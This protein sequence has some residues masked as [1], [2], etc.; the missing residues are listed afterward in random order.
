MVRLSGPRALEIAARLFS[1]R[2]PVS[3][4]PP[5]HAELGTL[6]HP[7]DGRAIDQVLLLVMPGPQSFTG[8]DVVEFS[9]HGSPFLTQLLVEAA[10]VAGARPASPGEFTRR[11]VLNGRLD[12]TQAE[13]IADLIGARGERAL[14]NALAQLDGGLSRRL[15]ELREALLSALAPLEAFLDFGDDVPEAPG[16][17]A[18]RRQLAAV[19][20][21]LEALIG[22]RGCARLLTEG[23]R[24]VLCG[25]PNVGKSSLLNALTGL[26]RALVH[27]APG[28]TRD[29]VDVELQLAGLPVRLVDTAG[30]RVADDPVEQAGVVRARQSADA[31]T[32]LLFL[33][34]G[35]GPVTPEDRAAF[36][37]LSGAPALVVAGKS[38]LGVGPWAAEFAE[39]MGVRCCHLSARTGRGVPELLALL[40]ARLGQQA[41]AEEDMVM[42]RARHYEALERARAAVVRAEAGLD[43]GAWADMLAAELRLSLDALDDITGEAAGPELLDRIFHTFCIG[44]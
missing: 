30:L 27:D 12:L 38:D 39:N 15:S 1:G 8:E 36:A 9:T 13:A 25:R 21:G 35:S 20:A 6:H 5:R 29:T 3:R 14:R 44:K 10:V 4:I 16:A 41:G 19:R 37:L 32:L 34:D 26:D 11:A 28:T 40:A 17:A 43:A 7:V 42:T 2:R 18:M 22:G 23:A 31:A 33:I 24:V